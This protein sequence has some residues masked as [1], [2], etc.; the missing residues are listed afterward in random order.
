MP[1]L[2]ILSWNVLHWCLV[3]L[4]FATFKAAYTLASDGNVWLS[5]LNEHKKVLFWKE[6]V[7]I[8]MKKVEIVSTILKYEC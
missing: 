5:I 7:F 2:Y 4:S 6:P 3:V 1:L 8:K